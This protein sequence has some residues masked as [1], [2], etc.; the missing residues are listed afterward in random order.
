MQVDV[1]ATDPDRVREGRRRHLGR[2]LSRRLHARLGADVL[3][4]DRQ[5]RLDA[6]ALADVGILRQSI[7]RIHNVRTQPQAF[8]ARAAVRTRTLRLQPVEPG[9]TQ[10]FRA[11]EVPGRLVGRDVEKI[12]EH[13]IV[14]RPVHERDIARVGARDEIRA[15]DDPAVTEE[16]RRLRWIETHVERLERLGLRIKQAEQLSRPRRREGRDVVTPERVVA[17]PVDGVI[18]TREVIH[19]EAAGERLMIVGLR[20]GL[21]ARFAGVALRLRPGDVLGARHRQQIAELRRIDEHRRPQHEA[22]PGFEVAHLHSLHAIAGRRRRRRLMPE[23]DSHALCGHVRREHFLEHRERDARFVA[24][25]GDAAVAGIQP[26]VRARRFGE[27]KIAGIVIT[28]PLP[29]RKVAARAAHCFDQGIFVGRH[30]L[31]RQ[32]AADPVSLLGHDHPPPVPRRRQRRRA[33]AGAA[34]DDDDVGRE[35]LLRSSPGGR[36]E[37]RQGERGGKE[38]ARV[39]EEG[40]AGDHGF[41]RGWFPRASAL[42]GGEDAQYIPFTANVH[43]W[44]TVS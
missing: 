9:K 13:V 12:A 29:K 38:E 22:V 32:L 26:R 3:F 19:R 6:A 1:V 30:R 21:R 16:A 7:L 27:G 4:R 14:L 18:L 2:R 8:P 25:F 15:V 39:L 44:P 28:H 17:R 33:P 10:L 31:R 36:G 20:L 42:P 5:L 43:D 24:E 41:Y 34:A 23:Q 11:V 40:A 37:R 35:F